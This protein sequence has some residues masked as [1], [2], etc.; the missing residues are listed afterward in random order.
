MNNR[1]KAFEVFGY[2]TDEECDLCGQKPC[3]TEPRF[4]YPTCIDC[5]DVPPIERQR[6][7]EEHN[8]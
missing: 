7:Q 4:L 6:L 1:K 2:D 5:M 3:K 8:S